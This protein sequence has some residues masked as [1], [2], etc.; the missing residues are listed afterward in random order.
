M[1]RFIYRLP[2]RFASGNESKFELGVR[3][4]D[5][6]SQDQQGITY[7]E[8]PKLMRGDELNLLVVA[9]HPQT[10]H[11]KGQE[12]YDFVWSVEFHKQLILIAGA[13][14]PKTPIHGQ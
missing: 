1:A 10:G 13:K 5:Q 14:H 3:S 6:T 4:G 12:K 2:G 11:N 9:N 7:H 8:E